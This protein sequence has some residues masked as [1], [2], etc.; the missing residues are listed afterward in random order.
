[1]LALPKHIEQHDAWQRAAR[2]CIEARENPTPAA[3]AVLTDQFHLAL[4]STYQAD[5]GSMKRPPAESVKRTARAAT[6]Q[7]A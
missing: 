2:L 5:L 7:R 3:I 1:M 6:R 4:F